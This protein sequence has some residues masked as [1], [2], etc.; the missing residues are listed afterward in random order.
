MQTISKR[1]RGP[2]ALWIVVA[3][4]FL[5]GCATA[6]G[7]R[8][9]VSADGDQGALASDPAPPGQ[10]AFGDGGREGLLRLAADVEAHGQSDVALS[11]YRR[12]VTVSAETPS[13]YVQLGDACQR[14][15]K[16]DEAIDAYREALGKSPDDATAMLGIG[17]ALVRKGKPEEGLDPLFKAAPIVNTAAAYDRLGVA[18]TLVG[19]FPQAETSF[20]RAAELAPDDLDIRTNSALAAALAGHDDTAVATI[21]EVVGSERAELRHQRD[22]IIVLGLIGRGAEARTAASSGLSQSELR[23]LLARA[24][25]IRAMTSP[26]ARAKALG[27]ITG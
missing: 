7:W 19:A 8:G 5:S 20:D 1:T 14:A 11:L 4:G 26:K 10:P 25:T 9:Q 13:A 21:R 2:S 6:P 23:S 15:G 3:A 24:S 12:A 16:L 18:Q 22:F 27:T 17:T